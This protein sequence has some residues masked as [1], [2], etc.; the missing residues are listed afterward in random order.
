MS[1]STGMGGAA[2]VPI[3]TLQYR[4]MSLNGSR[5]GVVHADPAFVTGE[6]PSEHPQEPLSPEAQLAARIEQERAAAAYDVE[7]KLRKEYEQKL[8]AARAPVA[9]LISNFE[10]ERSHY[11]ARVEAEIV[12]LALAIAAKILHREA[13]VDPMLVAALVRLAVEKMRDGSAVT[14]RVSLGRGESWKKFFA[15]LPGNI[16]VE[17]SEDAQLSEQDCVLE[18]ELGSANFGLDA[19]LKEVE[20]GFFDLL[21]LRPGSR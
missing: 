20:Q 9:T 21:A 2:S 15:S 16:R 14:L 13:Q 18:T 4:D 17:V 8:L 12:Q 6:F 7:Q 10:A 3:T 1:S 19:Q 11:Y 5:D